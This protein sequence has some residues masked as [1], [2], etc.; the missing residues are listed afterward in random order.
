MIRE[1][2]N[3]SGGTYMDLTSK[4]FT[5]LDDRNKKKLLDDEM[6]PPIQLIAIHRN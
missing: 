2:Q 4:F 3:N 1:D 6:S 5:Y